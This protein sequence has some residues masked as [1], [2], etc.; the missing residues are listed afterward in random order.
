MCPACLPVFTTFQTSLSLIF[1][2]HRVAAQLPWFMS[3][4]NTHT[5]FL[6]STALNSDL[7]RRHY[8]G[9][10][11]KVII[12]RQDATSQ[13]RD[14]HLWDWRCSQ[15]CCE[16]SVFLGCDAVWGASSSRRFVI[17]RNNWIL[18]LVIFWEWNASGLLS[19]GQRPVGASAFFF[20]NIFFTR[21]RNKVT[22]DIRESLWLQ[23]ISAVQSFL[24]HVYHPVLPVS[25]TCSL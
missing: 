12:S 25:E 2:F 16:D 20:L 14:R 15:R 10:T 8:D 13:L 1:P 17:S 6:H 23:Q 18:R 4:C 22:S 9:L 24:P 11:I 21:R 7:W 19:P 5:I 3:L